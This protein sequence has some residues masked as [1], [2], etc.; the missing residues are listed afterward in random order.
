MAWE[1]ALERWKRGK[2]GDEDWRDVKAWLESD[3]MWNHS[4][5]HMDWEGFGS[6]HVTLKVYGMHLY[7]P[8]WWQQDR[9]QVSTFKGGKLVKEWIVKELLKAYEW[10]EDARNNGIV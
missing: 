7:S 2:V 6:H 5:V 9:F 10:I 4:Y 8:K 1:S 3:P